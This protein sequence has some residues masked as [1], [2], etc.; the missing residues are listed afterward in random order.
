AVMVS[1]SD[2]SCF[3][4]SADIHCLIE[5]G[6][7]LHPNDLRDGNE[8]DTLNGSGSGFSI[9]V[10]LTESSPLQT[11][12]S[13]FTVAVNGDA[14][15]INS[16]LP[17]KQ[18]MLALN[19]ETQSI[20]VPSGSANSG[21]IYPAINHIYLNGSGELMVPGE[22]GGIIHHPD[23]LI[24]NLTGLFWITHEQQTCGFI[25]TPSAEGVV[26]TFARP[27]IYELLSLYS[28][29]VNPIFGGLTGEI[30]SSSKCSAGT[31]ASVYWFSPRSEEHT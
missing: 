29:Q 7:K 26:P 12:A 16:S 1:N 8:S 5:D 10:R 6:N 2:Y 31:P 3:V 21:A 30:Q 15:G 9:P 25:P 24:D 11:L 28:D 22:Y 23:C 4:G 27:T 20:S 14:P 19:A 18:P 17:I 13:W